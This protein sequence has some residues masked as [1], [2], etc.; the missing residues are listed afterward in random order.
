LSSIA[1]AREAARLTAPNAD[2]IYHLGTLDSFVDTLPNEINPLLVLID[3][4]HTYQGVTLDI[5]T[6]YHMAPL[7][8]AAIFHDFGLRRTDTV[9]GGYIAGV[10][11][12]LFD[13]LGQNFPYTPLGETAGR[14]SYLPTRSKPG[15]GG[16][17]HRTGAPEAIQIYCHD[18]AILGSGTL[19]GK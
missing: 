3:A 7:P 2:I 9:E 16:F 11:S 17:Y 15:N 12:A 1:G 5:A 19:P 4:D 13:S 6:L 8:H 10:D 18:C 14:G